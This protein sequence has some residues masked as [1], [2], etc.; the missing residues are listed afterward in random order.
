MVFSTSR[1][2]ATGWR[3]WVK[4]I[5]FQLISGSIDNVYRF[6]EH[7][8]YAAVAKLENAQGLGPCPDETG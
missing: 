5:V 6:S 3:D 7:D 1:R 8:V 2:G 4:D